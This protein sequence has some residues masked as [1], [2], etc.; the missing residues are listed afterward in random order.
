MDGKS[1]RRTISEAL[2]NYV[3]RLILSSFISTSGVYADLK[4]VVFS[5]VGGKCKVREIPTSCEC[6][7]WMGRHSDCSLKEG[8]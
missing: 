5:K 3:Y 2:T 1:Q 4:A 6:F 7:S 8:Q